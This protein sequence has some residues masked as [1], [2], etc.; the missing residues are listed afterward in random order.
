M[1]NMESVV[2][3][4]K[5]S[6]AQEFVN[7]V[8]SE[9][10]KYT[11]DDLSEDFRNRDDLPPFYDEELFRRGQK[12][13]HKHIFGLFLSKCL[14][15][16]AVLAVPSILKVLM[17]T[18]MSGTELT[19]YK[20]YVS[21][22]L[23][24]MVWYDSDFKPGSKL[25]KSIAD[26]RKRHNSASN[27]SCSAG[28]NRITQ[29]DMAITQFGFM[30]ISVCRSKMVGI[31]KASDEEW[32]GFIHIWR[33]IGYL[34]GIEDRFNL[35]SGTV[36]ETRERCNILMEQVFRPNIEQKD[37]NFI[38]MARN[39]I[40]ALKCINIFIK[41]ETIMYYLHILS[42]DENNNMKL[43]STCYK[44]NSSQKSNLNFL[45]TIM[46]MLSWNWFRIFQ[47][48]CHMLVLWLMK[49]FPLLPA[50]QFGLSNARVRI[51][52]NNKTN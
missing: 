52:S 4:T 14:G 46:Y 5:Y 44:L 37:E 39:M 11:C 38:K 20:R 24:M 40:H 36:E 7:S 31:H 6:S 12:F 51:L 3:K 41:F 27:R 19:A 35:C 47:N 48:Y 22:I 32:E 42:Q 2:E 25:W 9:G 13:F 10:E 15:L 33:V 49:V 23:H 21:T 18:R 50:Y 26:V 30:G 1:N 29:K 17:F 45:I 43:Q 28:M 16:V 34:M 8:L